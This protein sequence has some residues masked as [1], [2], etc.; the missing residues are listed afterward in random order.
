M[1]QQEAVAHPVR[2][3]CETVCDADPTGTHPTGLLAGPA[4]QSG[5]GCPGSAS[6]GRTTHE[7]AVRRSGRAG[8]RRDPALYALGLSLEYAQDQPEYVAVGHGNAVG[9]AHALVPRAPWL[10]LMSMGVRFS[11]PSRDERS[12]VASSSGHLTVI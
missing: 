11:A 7:C 12:H 5:Q 9:L 10:N 1:A 4:S 2:S 3:V 6:G 8:D